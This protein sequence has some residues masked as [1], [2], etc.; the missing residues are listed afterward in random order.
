MKSQ[1]IAAVAAFLVLVPAGAQKK[2]ASQKVV[3]ANYELA[4]RFSAKRVSNMVYS[5]RINPRWFKGDDRFWYDWKTSQGTKYFIVDPLKGTKKEVF[6]M[7]R[8]AMDLTSI[9]KDPF[10]AQHIPFESL[11]LVDDKAFTFDIR[12]S[13]EETDSTKF[14]DGKPGK[15]VF[16][17]RYDIDGKKLTEV[18][19][20]PKLYPEWANVSPDGTIGIYVKNHNLW[21]MDST[22]L[23]K[24][25]K[26][27]KDSTIVEKALTLD[28]TKDF[29]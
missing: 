28:G 18:P 25:A 21:V 1:L 7:D 15:K 29:S 8:L 11:K 2:A 26:D 27:P 13:A 9:V 24:A 4:E 16:H 14:K 19:E 22:S 10:D 3:R 12:S 20:K 6:D 17:F 5:T 23:R